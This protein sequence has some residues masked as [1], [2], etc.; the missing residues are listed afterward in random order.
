MKSVK[1]PKMTK[2]FAYY[3]FCFLFMRKKAFRKVKS[4]LKQLI[5][6]HDNVK[7]VTCPTEV[8]TN[9]GLLMFGGKPPPSKASILWMSTDSSYVW[10]INRAEHVIDLY[11]YMAETTAKV[12]ATCLDPYLLVHSWPQIFWPFYVFFVI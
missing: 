3:I 9:T 11:V 10:Y 7:H 12:T 5:Y 2:G 6:Y 4:L 8:Q 1:Y